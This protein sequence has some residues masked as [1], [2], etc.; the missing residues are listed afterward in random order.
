MFEL[1]NRITDEI[2]PNIVQEH[3]LEEVITQ[4][5]G[6]EFF[7]DI[8]AVVMF[9]GVEKDEDILGQTFTR[10]VH[11]GIANNRPNYAGNNS[12]T[13][14]EFVKMIVRSLSCR[15]TNIGNDT[16]YEDVLRSEWYSEYIAFATQEGW[17]EGA[18]DGKFHPNDAITR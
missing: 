10:D 2:C 6:Q 14:A 11:E 15:Y 3:E 1:K 7:D 16:K 4:D 8:S 13:R 5:R 18:K 12:I 9:R 17:I